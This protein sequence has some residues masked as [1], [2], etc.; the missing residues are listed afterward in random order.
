MVG[1]DGNG[2]EV[3]MITDKY[4]EAPLEWEGE[5]VG[6]AG[7]SNCNDHEGCNDYA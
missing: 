5:G 4:G 1:D 7:G 2:C 6:E 3:G